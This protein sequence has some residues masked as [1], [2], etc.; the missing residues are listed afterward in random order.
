VLDAIL[1][2]VPADRIG[3][4]HVAGGSARH[5]EPGTT[6]TRTP[7]PCP[8]RCSACSRTWSSARRAPPVLLEARRRLP[9][10][11]RAHRRARRHRRGDPMTP[12]GESYVSTRRVGHFDGARASGRSPSARP[13]RRRPR[14]GRPDPPGFDPARLA[15]ARR[16]PAAQTGRRGGEALAG[17][18]RVVGRPLVDGVRRAPR[19]P[20]AG[21]GLRDGWYLARAPAPRPQR[22]RR[23]RS[24]ASARRCG[25]T[26]AP[27]P[28]RLRRVR[29]AVAAVCATAGTWPGRCSAPGGPS[30]RIRDVGHATSRAADGRA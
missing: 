28:P 30:T 6:T 16:A 26:T 29:A 11:R 23:P 8:T 18:R 9:T 17:A 15:V 21:R 22:R 24:S 5:D 2:R 1:D 4:V 3:Y 20:R 10:R 14:R 7:T 27:D 19:R 12:H 25:A 13:P